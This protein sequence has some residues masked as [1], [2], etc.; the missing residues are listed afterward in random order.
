MLKYIIFVIM[1]ILLLGSNFENRKEYLNQASE[2]IE[3]KI[4]R[5]VLRSSVY[6]T[7]PW[8]FIHSDFFL[9]QVVCLESSPEPEILMRNLMQI[10][11]Y[12][13]RKRTGQEYSSRLIDLD[14]LFYG[15]RIIKSKHLKI[16]HPRLHLRKFTLIPLNELFQDF[17]HPE[18]GISIKEL[19]EACNDPLAVK[20]I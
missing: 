6:E 1:I 12:L 15:D 9:N 7:E 4:G 17:I 8:G 3:K 16:P 19:L 20:R 14:I 13:G 18:L 11:T 5:I 10:E 2:L